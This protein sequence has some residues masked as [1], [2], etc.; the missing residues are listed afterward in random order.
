LTPAVTAQTVQTFPNTLPATYA[1]NSWPFNNTTTAGFRTQFIYDG[2]NISAKYP[3]LIQR[4]RMR[5][6]SLTATNTGLLNG[7][8][9][10]LST[11][12]VAWN[13][14]TTTFANHVGKD[15]KVVF[16]GNLV[17]NATAWYV[18]I[19]LTTP[20]LYDPTKG[21]LCFDFVRGPTPAAGNTYPGSGGYSRGTA[22]APFKANRIWGAPTSATGSLDSGTTVTNGYA[23]TAEIT[24]I[25]AAGLYSS[26]SSDKTF[27]P[28]PL[29]VQFRD[30]TYSSA[31]PVK[32][33][34]WDLDGDNKV[35]ST[36]QNPKFTYPKT[37]FDAQYDV[38]LTTADGT[39]P[40]SKVTM[41]KYI[42]VD[43]STPTAV[44]FGLGS[45][46]KP[47]PS[48]IALPKNSSIYSASAGI[49]GFHFVSPTTFVI[50]GFQAPNEYT[51]KEPNQ[52]V[53]CYVRAT[54]PTGA[55]TAVAA[56]VK[57]FGTGSASAILKPTKPIIVQKG[58][59]VGVFGAC[60]GTAAAS[61]LRNAYAPGAFKTDVLGQAFT[62]ERM[63]MNADPRA[64]KGIGTINPTT[65][66]IARVKVYVA[67]HKTTPPTVPSMTS[68]GLPKLGTTPSLDMAPN[69]SA[70][71]GVVFM[72]AGRLPVPVPTMFGNLLINPGVVASFF[73][74]TGAG[75]LPLPIPNASV[76]T[77]V[78]V[79]WQ[80]LAF[81]LASNTFGMTNGTEWYIGK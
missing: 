21:G 44:D 6:S 1:G 62:I 71:G 26:F 78:T 53:I 41:T 39:H 20:F 32:S 16:K 27:G 63:W 40:A 43:P 64:N 19:K 38:T 73:V 30:T 59:W 65:G 74:P 36:L 28:G 10:S 9:I 56:D 37:G 80:G 81:D 68:I 77:G 8:T 3:V 18:D 47:L 72:S 45:S 24:W 70:Q 5:R 13:A 50:T 54:A 51:T 23:N 35:D 57:F 55:Y 29:T 52:T 61:L 17:C 75:Q 12:P 49:R 4:V 15:A 67:N 31:G 66:T 46:N 79:D 58:E 42:T 48:H 14:L 60:H 2:S 33:W 11:S 69:F 76:L 34:A 25:P 22:T 7:V